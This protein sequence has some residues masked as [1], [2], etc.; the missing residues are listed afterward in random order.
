M[1]LV[2]ETAGE[3]T[4]FWFT[5]APCT[6]HKSLG[7][8]RPRIDDAERELKAEFRP[9]ASRLSDSG[10]ICACY[11]LRSLFNSFVRIALVRFLLVLRIQLD[12]IA[13]RFPRSQHPVC[14]GINPGPN[15]RAR[16]EEEFSYLVLV[17][18]GRR[19]ANPLTT[20]AR[21]T[22]KSLLISASSQSARSTLG[23]DQRM[24]VSAPM[25]SSQN[26]T[27]KVAPDDR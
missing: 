8:Q 23:C 13:F 11:V 18:Y 4:F 16:A 7:V 20:C 17:T 1:C 25:F 2:L 22:P 24:P 27:P 14:G 10:H 6:L 21:Q 26:R 19:G 5:K 3:D 12:L 9:P 15:C